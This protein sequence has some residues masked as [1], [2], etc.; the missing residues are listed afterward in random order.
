[1]AAEQDRARAPRS[2]STDA[3]TEPPS[4]AAT[5]AEADN[6]D[7][8]VDAILDE[9]DDVLEENAAEFVA[10]FVQKGGE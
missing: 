9:I 4:P 10:S 2:E 7:E 5:S 6:L 1:M 3:Q 8:S